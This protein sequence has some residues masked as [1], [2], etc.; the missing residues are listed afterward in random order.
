M[1]ITKQRLFYMIP[2]CGV[3]LCMVL[4]G[5]TRG[6]YEQPALPR[7]EV[8]FE[9]HTDL[10]HVGVHARLVGESETVDFFQERFRDRGPD[11][12]L[13]FRGM[14]TTPTGGSPTMPQMGGLAD[15]DRMHEREAGDRRFAGQDEARESTGWGWL[16]DDVQQMRGTGRGAADVEL[17]PRRMDD[18]D[19][20]LISRRWFDD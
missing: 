8:W 13:Q 3:A 11:A 7:D 16:A 4:F 19:D 1:M 10:A 18:R 9:A 5:G 6:G 12:R 14:S 17:F 20:D 2:L 15:Q